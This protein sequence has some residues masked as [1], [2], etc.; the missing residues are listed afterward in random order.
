[1][2][3]GSDGSVRAGRGP[4]HNKAPAATAGHRNINKKIAVV[5]LVACGLQVARPT[6][7]SISDGFV[8]RGGSE[9]G[10]MHQLWQ[11]WQMWLEM[12][13]LWLWKLRIGVVVVDGAVTMAVVWL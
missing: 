7:T 8:S 1:M 10:R 6:D 3:H 13:Q 5:V 2:R 9:G 11:L 4:L 12:V